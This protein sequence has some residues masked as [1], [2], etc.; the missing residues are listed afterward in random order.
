M[1]F[2]KGNFGSCTQSLEIFDTI[3]SKQFL[4]ESFHEAW[5]IVY[6]TDNRIFWRENYTN[7]NSLLVK[8]IP[9]CPA[10]RGNCSCSLNALPVYFIFSFNF[11]IFECGTVKT[12]GSRFILILILDQR[13]DFAC[14]D[15][16]IFTELSIGGEIVYLSLKRHMF[17][18]CTGAA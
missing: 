6:E 4:R 17:R 8:L 7:R 1:N 18:P 2:A 15:L 12:E 13:R 10:K 5:I 11:S 3:Q 16:S 14:V 9:Q